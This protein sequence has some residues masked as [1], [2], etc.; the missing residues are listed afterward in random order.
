MKTTIAK[1]S[2]AT[3]V[4]V[5][6]LAACSGAPLS[7]AT[8]SQSATAEPTAVPV[9]SAAVP[10]TVN[11]AGSGLTAYE[12]ALENIYATVNPAVVSIEVTT[13]QGQALGSGFVWDDQ[14]HIVTN[15]HVVAD[16]TRIQVKFSDGSMVAA[17]LVGADA[18]SDL[19]VIK[20]DKAPV[21]LVPI[22]VGDSTKVKVGQV[23]V[24]IGNPF[25]LENTMTA[26]IVSAIGRTIS[27][28][29]SSTN[30]ATGQT[31]SIPDIIQTDAPINPGNSGG[32]LVDDQ[33]SL[34]GVNSQI[35]SS[36][37]S[38]AGIGF[39]I[40]S[41]LVSKVVPALIKDGKYEHPYL[42][43]TGTTLIPDLATAMKLDSAQRGVLVVAVSV[44]GPASK[45]GLIGSSQTTTINGQDVNV[46]G[47]V[48]TAADGKPINTMD[49]LIA[50][51]SDQTTVGQ[52]I[53]LSI[54][55]DGKA[56]TI[57]VTLTGRPDIST[58]NQSQS[59]SN[60]PSGT[61][62]LGVN[63]QP[64]TAEI[65]SEMGLAKDQTGLIVEQVEPGSPA[66]DAGL[67]GSFKPVLINGRR[68]LI[69]GDV[70]TT[71]DGQAVTTTEELV[72]II[73]NSSNGQE[74]KISILRDGKQMDLTATLTERP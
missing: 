45:A 65:A 33:G 2:F 74:I 15:D 73:Q 54:L 29:T 70:I 40:P 69:G 61:I 17:S 46:G 10:T 55:R 32:P 49:D 67:H 1:I 24:A 8:T 64:L 37:Q 4:V 59:Q 18:D 36:G 16:A 35:E 39:A 28:S 19:A 11:Q 72:N 27:A 13:P 52:K 58:A 63:V 71:V 25:G 60:V 26:G 23:A 38:N 44:D 48:I 22:Q 68:V 7:A 43:I 14:G 30:S 34:I 57:D 62:W 3:L 5:M 31:F 42:G 20:V 41:A 56:Q 21:K 12:A 6:L 50:Y 66:D 51:L 47:D 9:T 53:Q